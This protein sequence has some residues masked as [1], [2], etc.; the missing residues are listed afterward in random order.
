MKCSAENIHKCRVEGFF[1]LFPFP[2][3]AET[4]YRQ[5][6]V[7]KH[8]KAEAKNQIPYSDSDKYRYQNNWASLVLKKKKQTKPNTKP[9]HKQKSNRF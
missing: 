9:N 6:E 4:D 1:C 5:A 7:P 8:Q 2:A 3:S